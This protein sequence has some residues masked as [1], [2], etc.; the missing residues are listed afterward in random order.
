[1]TDILIWGPAEEGER[2]SAGR[3]LPAG[4][5]WTCTCGQSGVGLPSEEMADHAAQFHDRSHH[6]Q[7][8]TP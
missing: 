2:T 3:I 1:M 8:D 7:K 6:R 5:V 4:W